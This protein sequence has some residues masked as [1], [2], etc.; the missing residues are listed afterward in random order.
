MKRLLIVLLASISITSWAQDRNLYEKRVYVDGSDSLLY[1]IAYP[2]D[3]NPQEEYPVILFMHG[4]GERASDNERQLILGGDLFVAEQVREEYPAIVIF[5]QCPTNE[6]WT[7]RTKSQREGRSEWIFSFPTH[8]KPPLSAALVNQ[9]MDEIIA[10]P[11]TAD[12]QIY[13]MGISMGGIGTLEFL[14]RW[15]DKYAAAVV[16]CGGHDAS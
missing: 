1:R 8:C 15:G 7:H 16:I 10:K 3:F 5:P 13:I 4:A 12:N 6:M 14:Y 2:K 9:L 11:Y